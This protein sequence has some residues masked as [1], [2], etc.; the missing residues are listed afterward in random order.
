MI[1]IKELNPSIIGQVTELKCQLYL[2]EQGYNVLLPMGNHQ[3]YDLVI[4]HNGKFTKIQVKHSSE[5]DNGSSFLVRTRYDV[6]DVSKNQRIKKEFYTSEDCDYFMTEFNGNFYIFPV[7]GTSETKLWLKDVR[8]KTQKKASD[9][10]A[11]KVLQE[12]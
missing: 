12:M 4:E 3:K 11:E 8:L 6:R 10:L 1:A 5:Q 2:V 9:Y 7:F